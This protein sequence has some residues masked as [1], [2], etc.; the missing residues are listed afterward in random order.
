[1]ELD[2]VSRCLDVFAN[3]DLDGGMVAVI[4]TL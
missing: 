4:D 2:A 1:M 3:A